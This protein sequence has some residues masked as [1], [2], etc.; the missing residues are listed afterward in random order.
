M[1]CAVHPERIGNN[2]CIKCGNWYCNDCIDYINAQP[3][4]KRCKYGQQNTMNYVNPITLIKNLVI[5]L[6]REWRIVFTIVYF[7]LFTILLGCS[8][9][10]TLRYQIF[11]MYIPTVIYLLGGFFFY[12]LFIKN[13]LYSKK[14]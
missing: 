2:L 11:L 13:K 10:L 9:Y 12:L 1:N 3:I 4:C 8:I 14:F 5:Q 6:P 7:V